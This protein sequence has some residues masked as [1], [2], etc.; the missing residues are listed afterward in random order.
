M[1]RRAA[2]GDGGVS[3]ATKL[4]TD[5][6]VSV[7]EPEVS[8]DA[9]VS[10]ASNAPNEDAGAAGTAAEA[11]GRRR[12][13]VLALLVLQIGLLV[14]GVLVGRAWYVGHQV[15]LAHQQA[16]AA[17]RQTTVNFVSISATTVDRDLQRIVAG[18]TGEFRDEFTRAMPQ[19]RE[20]VVANQVS[21]VGTA[22]RAGLVSGDL[23]SAV[24]LVA[25]DAT[26]H[27]VKAPDGRLTH[28][29]VQVDLAKDR[30]S[31]TW[32]VSR[33]QFVG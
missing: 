19:V 12:G 16:L 15:E 11:G 10:G 14:A 6:P 18:A 22:L 4:R 31:G 9:D 29:R 26:V 33:L 8:G 23:D 5:E 2:V 32:L 17:A 30:A 1:A 21:S 13:L 27:N 20:T 7:E 24:V 25:V 3:V 28:Y